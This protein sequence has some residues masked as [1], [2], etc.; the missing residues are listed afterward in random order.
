ME[1]I[2]VFCGSNSGARPAFARAARDLGTA[3]AGRGIA[4]VF[5][6]GSVGLMGQVADA[7]LEA[8]GEAIGVIPQSLVARELAHT[9]LTELHVVSTMHERKAK[10][11]ELSSAF[12]SLPGGLGTLD[13]TF[14]ILTWAQLGIHAKPFG[15]LNVD[16]YF[17]PLLAFLDSAVREGF[18]PAASR[19]RWIEETDPHGLISRLLDTR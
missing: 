2:C 11:V 18:V 5:G 7:A 15:L 19:A 8:G 9:G 4:L 12:I 16:G 6:G 14:E 3:L 1:R 13:E 17:T 10:M